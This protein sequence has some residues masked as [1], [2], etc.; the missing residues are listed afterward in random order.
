M[1]AEKT[2][3]NLVNPQPCCVTLNAG[4]AA[5]PADTGKDAPC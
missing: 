3:V 1:N 5:P 4:A 2:A